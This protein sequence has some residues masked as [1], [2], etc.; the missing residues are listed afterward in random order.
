MLPPEERAAA[1]SVT[2]VPRSLASALAPIP[3][4]VM[5]DHSLFGWPLVCAGGLKTLY[6]LLLLIQFRALRLPD[7]QRG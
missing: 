1:A 7:E 2:N 5:L 3:A 4:G 6:D